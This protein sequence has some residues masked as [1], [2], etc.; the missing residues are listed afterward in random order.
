MMMYR[1]HDKVLT[2][3]EF[4]ISCDMHISYCILYTHILTVRLLNYLVLVPVLM[5][6]SN[7]ESIAQGQV[8]PFRSNFSNVSSLV[9]LH[10]EDTRSLM[11]ENFSQASKSA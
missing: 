5:V 10:R 11:R 2:F 8:S 9:I 7:V 1:K 6:E 4:H 3:S